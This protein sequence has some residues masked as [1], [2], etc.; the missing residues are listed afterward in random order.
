MS[1]QSVLDAGLDPALINVVP[2]GPATVWRIYPQAYGPSGYNATN[3]GDA[4]FSPLVRHN[5]A[6]VPCL[7]A[8]TDLAVALME[9]VLREVPM[10]CAGEQFMLPNR[11]RESR[12]AAQ[13]S[14]TVPMQ[15]ADLSNL[16]LR[17]WGLARTDVI[18][19]DADHYVQTR[20][21]GL[22]IYENAPTAQ[23]IIWTSRQLDQ[24]K[25][26]VLFGDRVN[27]ATIQVVDEGQSLWSPMMQDTLTGL[28]RLLHIDLD[29]EP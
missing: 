28:A 25:C 3:L 11:H 6:V 7:Y 1:L 10:G 17:A 4:R 29:E 12:R 13:L 26:V 18:D 23:G 27:S 14:L 20:R 22:W 8:G 19:C 15:L 2:F 9:V 5:G 21:L 16:T 24:G